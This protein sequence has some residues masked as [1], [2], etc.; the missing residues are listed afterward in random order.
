MYELEE[1]LVKRPAWRDSSNKRFINDMI[2]YN[3][4]LKENGPQHRPKITLLDT[5]NISPSETAFKV[6]SWASEKQA[7]VSKN[8]SKKTTL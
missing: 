6:L 8:S 1:R 3:N 7:K 5:T 2:S 4:W